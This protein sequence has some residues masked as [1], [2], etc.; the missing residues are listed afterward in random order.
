LKKLQVTNLNLDQAI[1]APGHSGA[2]G[3]SHACH[4]LD[5][6][7]FTTAKASER[8]KVSTHGSRAKKVCV[9]SG[10]RTGLTSGVTDERAP[11]AR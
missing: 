5:A 6:P 8:A 4:T 7:L 10:E 1:F 2:H 11:L 9:L 3:T